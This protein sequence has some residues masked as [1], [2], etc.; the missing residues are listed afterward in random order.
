M[1]LRPCGLFFRHTC[2]RTCTLRL[3]VRLSIAPPCSCVPSSFFSLEYVVQNGVPKASST[4]MSFQWN[5]PRTSKNSS[6][7]SCIRSSSFITDLVAFTGRWEFVWE[8]HLGRS[9]QNI[10]SKNHD[11]W[12]YKSLAAKSF[13]VA[14]CFASETV[15]MSRTI[16]SY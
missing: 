4:V 6:L 3:S 12:T 5:P 15:T 11:K 16:F 9:D 13:S 2:R 7:T 10:V 14:N 1:V 8:K